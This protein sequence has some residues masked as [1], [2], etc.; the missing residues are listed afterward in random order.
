MCWYTQYD[1]CNVASITS[2]TFIALSREVE[3][4]ELFRRHHMTLYRKGQP[5]L[6]FSQLHWCPDSKHFSGIGWTV[7]WIRHGHQNNYCCVWIAWSSYNT[8]F[9]TLGWFY[10][11]RHRVVKFSNLSRTSTT[12]LVQQKWLF[13]PLLMIE[14]GQAP[15]QWLSQYKRAACTLPMSQLKH[16]SKIWS[17]M[18]SDMILAFLAINITFIAFCGNAALGTE[19]RREGQIL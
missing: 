12:D 16:W 10:E 4:I 5:A 6:R 2:I 1:S 19:N 14:S 9:Y 15:L 8:P 7:H 18:I 11:C 17:N 13:W 3:N